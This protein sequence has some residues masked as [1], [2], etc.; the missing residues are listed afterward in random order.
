[1]HRSCQ[2]QAQRF[3]I[4]IGLQLNKFAGRFCRQRDVE[5]IAKA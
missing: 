4:A 5:Q 3:A 2:A 1:M